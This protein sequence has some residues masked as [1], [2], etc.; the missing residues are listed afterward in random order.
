VNANLNLGMALDKLGQ[1]D[2][3]AS[4]YEVVLSLRPAHAEAHNYL[5]VLHARRGRVAKAA[6]HFRAAVATKPGYRDA[7]LNLERANRVLE[8]RGSGH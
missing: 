5:G 4:S 1:L 8:G 2:E 6:E 7:R 3:A